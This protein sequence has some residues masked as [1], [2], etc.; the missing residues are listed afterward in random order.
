MELIETK[1][2]LAIVNKMIN[3]DLDER[4]REDASKIYEVLW[5]GIPP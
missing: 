3:L 5:K 1:S 2:Y 4:K